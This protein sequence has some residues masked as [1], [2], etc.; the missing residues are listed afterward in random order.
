MEISFNPGPSKQ[1]QNIIFRHKTKKLPHPPLEFNNANVTQSV[2]QKHL[3]T[4]LES[5]LTVDNHLKILT[6]KINKTTGLLC[7]LQNLT[8]TVSTAI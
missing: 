2:Y 7:K 5:N 6:T 4:I 8:R 1:T 3:G